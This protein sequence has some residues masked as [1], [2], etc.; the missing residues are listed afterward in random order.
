MMGKSSSDSGIYLHFCMKVVRCV[1]VA[2]V[3][4]PPN[5]MLRR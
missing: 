3:V 4:H 5:A 2:S 1:H